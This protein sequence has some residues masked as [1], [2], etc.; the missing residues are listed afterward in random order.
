VFVPLTLGS[1]L[2]LFVRQFQKA[3]CLD[4]RF[5]GMSVEFKNKNLINRHYYST[6]CFKEI[7]M[8]FFWVELLG[9]FMSGT[10]E[11]NF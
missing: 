10:T 5:D 11:T 1:T 2:S 7:S 9:D 8:H 6:V 4:D 3:D